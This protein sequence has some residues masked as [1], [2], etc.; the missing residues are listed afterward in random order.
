MED[1]FKY[2][3]KE[4]VKNQDCYKCQRRKDRRKRFVQCYRDY[5][6]ILFS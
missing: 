3:G 5:H 2:G 4:M 1:D 6:K